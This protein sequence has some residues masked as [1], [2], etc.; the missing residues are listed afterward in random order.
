MIVKVVLA[1]FAQDLDRGPDRVGARE[2]D[3]DFLLFVGKVD[4][5]LLG[6]S[7]AKLWIRASAA[8]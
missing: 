1:A 8:W 3:V 5:G 7:K 6:T 4:V 2:L